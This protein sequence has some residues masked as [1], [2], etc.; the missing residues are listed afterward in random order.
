MEGR[1]PAR[2]ARHLRRRVR[3]TDPAPRRRAD[4]ARPAPRRRRE[5]PG[6]DRI[7]RSALRTQAGLTSGTATRTT[8]LRTGSRLAA[9]C[10]NRVP[11]IR[12]KHAVVVGVGTGWVVWQV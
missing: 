12:G 6:D 1:R 2:V 7:H 11:A 8:H 4:H 5:G 9:W 3:R 10:E